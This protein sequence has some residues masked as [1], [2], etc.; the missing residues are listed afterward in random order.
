MSQFQHE[1][2]TSCD[3]RAIPSALAS[4][5]RFVLWTLRHHPGEDKPRK[6]P[7]DTT[8]AAIDATNPTCW[9]TLDAAVAA[10]A[11]LGEQHGVGVAL[12][13]G[14]CGVDLDG[15]ITGDG[16]LTAAAEGIVAELNS[17]TEISPS[18]AGVHVLLR[19]ELPDGVRHK[20]TLPGGG[21]VEIY[22]H[23]RFFTLTGQRLPGTP[24][25]VAARTTEEL[26]AF[27]QRW[28]LLTGR[29]DTTPAGGTDGADGADLDLLLVERQRR[30][31]RYFDALWR[32]DTNG[33]PSP[34]EA[35]L[36]LCT[37]LLQLTGGDVRRADALFRQSGLMRDKWNESRGEAS[38]GKRTLRKAYELYREQLAAP[39]LVL[40]ANGAPPASP[41]G[42]GGWEPPIPLDDHRVPPFPVDVL[43]PTL[44]A[45]VEAVAVARQL[46]TDVP[47][48]LVLAVLATAGQRIVD[49]EVRPGWIEPLSLYTVS[50]LRSGERK[51]PAYADATAPLTAWE[52]R[53]A[54]DLE[55]VIAA[56]AT[57]KA[58][59]EQQLRH[60]EGRAAKAPR[61]E[62]AVAVA[63]AEALARELA[64][65]VVPARPRL[66]VD[67]CTPEALAKLLAEHG[68]R[69]GVFSDEG[70]LFDLVRG[71]YGNGP[72]F[73]VY[74]K[75]HVG[76]PL[77]VDRIGRAPLHIPRPALSVG[78]TVQ[79]AVL[80]GL[81]H[82]PHLRG[83]G[84]L[85]RF[86]YAWPV[87]M[88]GR[89]DPDPPPLPPPV[90]ARYHTVITTV[91]NRLAA[92]GAADEDTR[93]TQIQSSDDWTTGNGIAADPDDTAAPI[94]L[95]LSE[96]AYR[97][98]VAFQAELEPRLGPDGD[99]T[100]FADWANKL[101][102]TVVRLAGL[103]H[104][105]EWGECGAEGNPPATVSDETLA[106]ALVL[107]RYFLNHARYAFAAMGSD[108]ALDDARYL[109]HRIAA[110]PDHPSAY[111]RRDLLRLARRFAHV[112]DLD[113]AIR[114]L[115][116]HGYMREI[117]APPT[118]ATGTAG[119]PAGPYYGVNPL[120]RQGILSFLSRLSRGE[121][122]S[123]TDVDERPLRELDEPRDKKDKK[124]KIP[125]A[126]AS[127]T[128]DAPPGGGPESED[129]VYEEFIL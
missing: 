5:R 71:R 75:A 10:R 96:P 79:P 84:L 12:G 23:G 55:P 1:Y 111:S 39:A 103:L 115:L 81:H 116:R 101:A 99:L 86:L 20:A 61:H 127:G 87:T 95:R 31:D 15:I 90:R 43:P 9:V 53:R 50:V 114:V 36:T 69:L 85:A 60:A 72:N 98:L 121:G 3:V 56:A 77:R 14:L 128:G 33:Y 28:G 66:V 26:V 13:A 78:L 124:D 83:R 105:A 40:S 117:T 59:L 46:P 8:G 34:S 22:D 51:T 30:V 48:T 62:A 107:G 91:L 112:T 80:H 126:P 35:D 63:E 109:W 24:G 41:A 94:R 89:R 93:Q 19:G 29:H 27:C 129:V 100:P 82:D 108:P 45:F 122:M 120:A 123:D 18:R 125:L 74:L 17:Y 70:D 110:D 67:D 119:R 88:V 102:G 32:G 21:R 16:R 7:C 11:R 4:E 106:R 52:T 64:A 2:D 49:V 42:L 37:R 97:R 65:T 113:A 47:G 58:I 73:G 76:S 92:W 44:R 54:R 25:D 104:L 68:G 38:Y 57:R 118:P 6:V